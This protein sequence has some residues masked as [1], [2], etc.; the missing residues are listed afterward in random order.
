MKPGDRTRDASLSPAR[1]L[2]D[3]DKPTVTLSIAVLPIE[4]A[5][6]RQSPVKTP[7]ATGFIQLH[8]DRD[9]IG[10]E[11]QEKSPSVEVPFGTLDVY[12]KDSLRGYKGDEG[13]IS[14]ESQDETLKAA[15]RTPTR[16][17]QIS[18]RTQHRSTPASTSLIGLFHGWL[19]AT[20]L[21]NPPSAP[22]LSLINGRAGHGVAATLVF[23]GESGDA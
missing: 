18:P 23:G 22:Q 14:E 3:I 17:H 21:S 7:N 13:G 19:D 8:S 11:E 4:L 10:T 9:G 15:L 5:T 20:V 2:S 12:G 6:I 16:S 1:L